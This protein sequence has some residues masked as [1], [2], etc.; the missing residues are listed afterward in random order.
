MLSLS[1]TT[2][3]AIVALS[4]LN[5]PGG[6]PLLIKEVAEATGISPFYLA[7]IMV[8]LG[9]AGLITA[10]RGNRGGI[11]LGRPP[12]EIALL[13][14][15]DAI[16]GN[17]WLGR[18]L[19]GLEECSDERSCPTHAFWKP[20]REKLRQTMAETSLASVRRFE[21]GRAETWASQLRS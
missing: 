17:A 16:D 12:E 19:L 8:R 7:K 4:R 18:C 9:K 20:T 15:S 14:I 11:I 6:D 13:E 10:R 5:P 1:Q 3:Y 2:G 21:A